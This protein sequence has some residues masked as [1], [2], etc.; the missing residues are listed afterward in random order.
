MIL[1]LYNKFCSFTR[2]WLSLDIFA[3]IFSK[4]E[5]D[6]SIWT[7]ELLLQSY[8]ITFLIF[9]TLHLVYFNNTSCTF[10]DSPLSILLSI[11]LLLWLDTIYMT[12][13][14]S[15]IY[16]NFF[17]VSNIY[18]ILYFFPIPIA[19]QALPAFLLHFLL[20]CQFFILFIAIMLS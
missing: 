14:F 1:S 15:H 11:L 4:S 12:T 10:V 19:L 5:Y 6:F 17:V 3:P 8:F 7:F 16:S 18:Y 13:F 20:S 2:I 9:F